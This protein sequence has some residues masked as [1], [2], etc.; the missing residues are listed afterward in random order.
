M[1]EK[2]SEHLTHLGSQGTKY[3]SEYAPE[4]LVTLNNKQPDN[5]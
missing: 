3:S 4:V 5:D 2:E 1:R